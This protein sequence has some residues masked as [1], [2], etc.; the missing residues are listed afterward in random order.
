MAISESRAS[1]RLRISPQ[2]VSA[3]TKAVT[4]SRAMVHVIMPVDSSTV[5]MAGRPVTRVRS[6]PSQIGPQ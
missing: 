6:M 2:P 1:A 4:S 5:S 3:R